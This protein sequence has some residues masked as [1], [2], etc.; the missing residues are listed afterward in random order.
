MT[1]WFW[2]N[3]VLIFAALAASFYVYNIRYDQLPAE[4]PTHWGISG[5]PDAFTAK[6]NAWPNFYLMPGALILIALLTLVL[7]IISPVQFSVDT[8]RNTYGYAMALVSGLFA[9]IHGVLL[10]MYLHQQADFLRLFLPGMFLFFALLGNILGKVRRNFW[11]G[12][13]TPWTLADDQVWDRTHRLGAWLF[14]GYGLVGAVLALVIKQPLAV[15]VV[16]V[17]GLV[18]IAITTMVYSLVLYKS[19][20]RQGK[21][22]A[23]AADKLPDG[24]MT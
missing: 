10:W 13:R 19:L 12:I 17:A 1:R 20:Q 21:L 3:V 2:V 15:V 8:F 5:E 14:V 18:V 9:Y 24:A 4:I 23:Q 16:F 6:E 22:Q 11:M 7:P